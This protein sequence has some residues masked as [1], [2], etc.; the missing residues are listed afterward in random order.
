[1]TTNNKTGYKYDEEDD[2]YMPDTIWQ[3]LRFIF[4]MLNYIRKN[5]EKQEKELKNFLI[6]ALCFN[7]QLK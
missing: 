2:I 3:E 1:M 5:P 7:R 6:L 4:F